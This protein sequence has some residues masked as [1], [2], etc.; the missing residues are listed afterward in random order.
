VPS[1]DQQLFLGW[2]LFSVLP[3][4]YGVEEWPTHCPRVLKEF[5]MGDEIE[6]FIMMI[7]ARRVGETLAT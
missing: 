7:T 4:V 5:N 1:P 6:Y 3:H 2:C